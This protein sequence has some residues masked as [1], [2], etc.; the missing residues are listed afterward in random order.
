MA[1]D[2]G[3]M[4]QTIEHLKIIRMLSYPKLIAALTK[5]DLVDDETLLLAREELSG[6]LEKMGFPDVPVMPI[7]NTKRTGIG[8]FR[9][10]L[11]KTVDR[12]EFRHDN[13]KFRMN[14]QNRFSVKG[15]GTVVTGIPVSGDLSID[16]NLALLP[17]NKLTGVRGIQNYKLET[18]TTR[19]KICCALNLRD[20]GEEELE[21][22]MA[23][24]APGAYHA[25]KTAAAVIENCHEEFAVKHNMSLR[26]HSGTFESNVKVSLI[27]SNDLNPLQRGFA[28]LSLAKPAVLASGDKFIL[29]ETSPSMTVGGGT[30]ILPESF[31]FKRSSVD[32]GN[33]LDRAADLL[34]NGDLPGAQVMIASSPWQSRDELIRYSCLET[35]EA[36]KT[37]AEMTDSGFLQYLGGDVFIV[38]C[39]RRELKK[40]VVKILEK[41]HESH[42]Y[43]WGA[44]TNTLGKLTGLNK[45][46]AMGLLN[47]LC[48][49]YKEFRISHGRLSLEGFKPGMNEKQMRRKDAVLALIAEAGYECVARGTTITELDVPEKEFRLLV[50][51]LVEE[52]EIV[53]LGKHY[54]TTNFFKSCLEI[55]REMA[56]QQ[57]AVGVKEFQKRINTG[58]N[59]AITIL[60]KFDSLGVS[61]RM[62]EGRKLN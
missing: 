23:L 9:E 12:L 42:K 46:A 55:F 27:G 14:I 5:I 34:Q 17:G 39:R 6:F 61:V 20:I 33:R 15:I 19:A 40:Q 43:S 13:R 38:D 18:E 41:Y 8:E 45:T 28:R 32:F 56:E 50:N 35:A 11:E 52:K 16:E 24:A 54:M 22:G 48:A 53:V 25:T 36:E 47:F 49:N 60:E 62:P 58:R 59:I 3:V 26:F 57:E 1:A 2:D 44:D 30:V 51:I 37:I 7:S 10:K 29:R 4:P 21:R 31:L